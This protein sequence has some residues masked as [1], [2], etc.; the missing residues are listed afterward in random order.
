METRTPT[1]RLR[2]FQLLRLERALRQREEAGNAL[3]VRLADRGIASLYQA[4]EDAGAGDI[5][6]RLMRGHRARMGAG[7]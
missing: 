3:A 5:A 1:G 6:A 7:S 2:M 4:C